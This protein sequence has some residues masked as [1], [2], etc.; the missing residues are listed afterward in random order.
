MD[1]RGR[2][3]LLTAGMACVCATAL[4]GCVEPT[5]FAGTS[6]P[7]PAGNKPRAYLQITFCTPEGEGQDDKRPDTNVVVS[8]NA[9][10]VSAITLGRLLAG[11][12][13]GVGETWDEG[14]WNP[15][16]DSDASH[17]AIAADA[18][19][20]ELDNAT[21]T[22]SY[23]VDAAQDAIAGEEWLHGFQARIVD[24]SGKLRQWGM[25]R[26]PVKL[27][28]DWDGKSQTF[29]LAEESSRSDQWLYPCPGA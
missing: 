15:D 17:I 2:R 13:F 9:S 6:S 11:A 20:Q 27:N 23:E 22:L 24:P 4:A 29:K 26:R 16:P 5:W 14:T 10:P 8:L 19:S 25:S 21:L 1:H 28:E 12:Q 3:L 18:K 7:A